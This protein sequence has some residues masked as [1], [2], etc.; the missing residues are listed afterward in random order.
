MSGRFRT[1]TMLMRAGLAGALL[2]LAACGDGGD[3]TPA[4][5]PAAEATPA[6]ATPEPTAETTAAPEAPA[7]A[8]PSV[9]TAADG[10]AARGEPLYGQFCASCHGARGEGDGPVAASL[11]PKPVRHSDGA[12][13][14]ELSDEHLFK[15]IQQ[16]GAA[17]GKSPLMAPWSGTLSEAQI[18]DVV[19]FIRTLADPPSQP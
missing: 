8:T 3:A 16:G 10:V 19:A 6:P 7:E 2:G 15:V 11:N 5:A 17:V 14:N 13:M 18:W 4:A 12:Y 9:T 1:T